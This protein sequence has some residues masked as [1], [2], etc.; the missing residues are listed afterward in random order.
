MEHKPINRPTYYPF[1]FVGWVI[2]TLMLAML[3]MFFE[4]IMGDFSFD[5]SKPIVF[6]TK[7]PYVLLWVFM[8]LIQIVFALSVMPFIGQKIGYL[9]KTYQVN[10]MIIRNVAIVIVLFV[11][12]TIGIQ[13]LAGN[14]NIPDV[15]NH[16][17]LIHHAWFKMGSVIV[18]SYVAVTACT[19]L[20]L[21]INAVLNGLSP[22]G[23]MLYIQYRSLKVMMQ[24]VL[25]IIGVIITTSTVATVLLQKSLLKHGNELTTEM[26]YAYGLFNTFYI[27]IIYLP[28]FFNLKATGRKL[29][30]MELE[31]DKDEKLTGEQF[32][33]KKKALSEIFGLDE[34]YTEIFKKAV[35]ILGPL[36]ASLFA[37]KS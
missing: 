17:D 12:L 13:E 24:N 26:V 30:D 31:K 20:I 27:A 19:Y 3:I 21:L 28:V 35:P 14:M 18:C 15:L 4:T 6:F 25:N 11:G 22:D 32:L 33:A 8:A 34:D 16:E 36:L 29:V 1:R 9:I 37:M 5:H 10:N 7:E 2:I 23:V